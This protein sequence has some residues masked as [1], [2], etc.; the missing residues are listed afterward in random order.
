MNGGEEAIL[1]EITLFS[2]NITLKMKLRGILIAEIEYIN[3]NCN[4]YIYLHI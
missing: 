3:E 4:M 1:A 2:A